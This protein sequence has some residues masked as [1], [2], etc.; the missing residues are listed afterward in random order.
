M[1]GNF[2]IRH[3][4]RQLE[5]CR[6]YLVAIT[7]AMGGKKGMAQIVHIMEDRSVA[8]SSASL[9]SFVLCLN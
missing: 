2:Q 4:G 3:W 9:A 6:I 5:H 7:E 1:S 8:P